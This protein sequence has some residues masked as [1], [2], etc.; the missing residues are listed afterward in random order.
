MFKKETLN[1]NVKDK[2]EEKVLVIFTREMYIP[3]T[4]PR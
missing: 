1:L 3:K 2:K 4:D